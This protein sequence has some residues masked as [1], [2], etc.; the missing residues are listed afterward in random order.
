MSLQN[1]FAVIIAVQYE[2]SC[3]INL[4]YLSTFSLIFA[5]NDVLDF[6]KQYSVLSFNLCES[7]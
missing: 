5:Q 6:L 7:I 3:K 4:T 2:L 1:F